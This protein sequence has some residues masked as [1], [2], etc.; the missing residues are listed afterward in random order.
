MAAPASRFGRGGGGD[1]SATGDGSDVTKRDA[2]ATKSDGNS[3]DKLVL[4]TRAA[5]GFFPAQH[6]H[7]IG[8]S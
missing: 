7:R 5:V 3:D 4:A 2:C 8:D 6:H 1:E